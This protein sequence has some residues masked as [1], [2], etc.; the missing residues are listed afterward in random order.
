MYSSR[1]E[2]LW[3]TLEALVYNVEV[4][5]GDLP[6]KVGCSYRTLIRQLQLLKNL[7]LARIVRTEPVKRGR[8]RN[9]WE[10][11]FA[12]L[13]AFMGSEKFDFKT[14]D[15]VVK[16]IDR[17]AEIQKHKWLIFREWETFS[18]TPE[19][20]ELMANGIMIFCGERSQ[21]YLYSKRKRELE[22]IAKTW[23][24]FYTKYKHLGLYGEK[25]EKKEATIRA[26]HL[27]MVFEGAWPPWL[28]TLEGLN[29][30]LVKLWK[31]C[32]SN[33]DLRK[34]IQNQFEFEEERYKNTIKF[35]ELFQNLGL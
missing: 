23:G 11:T 35:K 13:T 17:I 34:F 5:Q 27:D 2:K 18:K 1:L 20:K 21:R 14:S 32:M 12:G 33:P 29:H 19:L 8:A 28:D 24:S 10:V 7:G 9:V 3:K 26:L 25:L 4:F 31:S 6:K 16:E 15:Y 22:E 30:A